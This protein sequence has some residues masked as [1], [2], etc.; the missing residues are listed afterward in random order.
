MI[1]GAPDYQRALIVTGGLF[2]LV[3]SDGQKGPDC[4][5][6]LFVGF[7]TY[8]VTSVGVSVA[9]TGVLALAGLRPGWPE[10]PKWAPSPPPPWLRPCHRPSLFAA[11]YPN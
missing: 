6:V 2:F 1:R 9:S 3:G 4:P 7:R 8:F 11:V 10:N 5:D